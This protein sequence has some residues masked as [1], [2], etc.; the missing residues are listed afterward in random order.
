[1]VFDEPPRVE[2]DIRSEQRQLMLS[3]GSQQDGRVETGPG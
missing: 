3:F 2:N 1:M